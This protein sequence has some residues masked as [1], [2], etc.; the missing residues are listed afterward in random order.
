MSDQK[1]PNKETGEACPTQCHFISNTHWDREWRFSAQRT[2]HMLV[3]MMDMLLDI[4]E[5]EPD[6]KHFHLDSQTMPLQDYLEVRPEKTELVRKYV[7]EGR[8]AVGPWFCLPDEYCVGGESLLRNLLLG[9]KMARVFGGVSK[10][11]YSPFGWGQISQMPQIYRGFGIDM[12]CFY[13]G[14]NPLIAPKSEFIWEAPDG[15][16][17]LASR[18]GKRP[19]YNVWY[20]VQRPAYFHQSNENNRAMSWRAGGAPFRF[21]DGDHAELD[22][23]YAHPAFDY[24]PA[25][26][27]AR[28]EQAL[29]EQDDDWST[30]HRFWSAGHDSS[31]PDIREVRM[32]ADCDAA[33]GG[34]GDVFHSTFKD[35]QDGVLSAVDR[36]TLPRRKGEMHHPFIKGSVSGLL[37]WVTS[38]RTPIKQENFR[39]ERELTVYAEP[40]AAFASLLGAPWPG[41]FVDLAYNYL[42]QNHGH[43]SIGACG[44]DI[45]YED[46]VSRFRQSREV[47]QCVLERAFLDV[48][49]AI[50]FPQVQGD[51]MAIVVYN[52][53]P[54]T[55]SEVID[56][57]L[58]IPLEW[59]CPGFAVR[60]E[61]GQP[62]DV[63]IL[64]KTF[65]QQV[66][67]SPNDTANTY[68][69]TR[70]IARLAVRGIPP[71]GYRTFLVTP[72][73]NTRPKNPVSM[74]T[75]PQTM[76][77]EHIAVTIHANGT[78][79]VLD[80]ATG[81]QHSGLGYF[82]D[83]GETGSPWEHIS[84]QNDELF[85]TLNARA[86]ITLL[87]DG[88]LEAAYRVVIPW[89]LPEGRTQDER[90]RSAHR[91]PMTITNTVTLHKDARWVEVTTE[92]DN[93]CEDHYLQV[94]FPTGIAA[95]FSAAQG[96]FDVVRRPVEKLDYTQYDEIPMTEQP[97]NSFADYSDGTAGLALLNEGL[98]AYEAHGDADGT[99]SLTLL[100]CFPLR[101]CVTTELLDYTEDKGSQ[102]LGHHS[103]RY[104]ILPHAGDWEQGQVWSA[105]ERFNGKLLAG[106]IGLSAH[107]SQPM[108]RSFVE[109]K[110][111]N[112]HLSAVKHAE[113]GKGWVV[114][115]FN[116]SDATVCNA[117]RLN[118]GHAAPACPQSPLDRQAAEFRLPAEPGPAFADV[119]LVT[120][121][122]LPQQPLAVA[123][124]GWVPFE[125]AGKRILTIRFA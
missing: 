54:Y 61:A 124:D 90:G 77:N 83:S 108:A 80:K 25:T 98:K 76:E 85:T 118:G 17:I 23:Q 9:H 114:R 11:G 24:D 122:E 20:I 2:R 4:L 115:L 62:L 29:R 78:L 67:Q 21:I 73:H 92:L 15:T 81:R 72:D 53:T 51:A 7:T 19:R 97:M 31:C 50:A 105:A 103:F 116:P 32:I 10:T 46:V 38:A 37:G 110:Q 49:G 48:A 1:T 35:F 47:A 113:D 43:D 55:R 68:D 44:R 107:G 65:C 123:A 117:I 93:P 41:A 111:E 94:S 100:R 89:S 75:R 34:Q 52:P 121:E 3:Y 27:P 96:Q 57:A 87:R 59:K 33:L 112:L 71:M 102:C 86:E 69:S 74:V 26:I 42:L 28:A 45:V 70:F 36:E 79:D 16:D 13:R 91:K 18:L 60:D 119:G 120:L 84:P 63:Q 101:I 56:T 99:V 6:F 82:R 22:Y 30:P 125:I 88:A 39:A 64:Q 109:L 95:Q 66:V 5:N 106:Q 104:A 12:M 8:L 40:L 14:L 58:D